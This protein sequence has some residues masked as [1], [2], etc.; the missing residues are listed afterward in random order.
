LIVSCGE[1]KTS[2]NYPDQ[3]QN[4]TSI[5]SQTDPNIVQ[6]G[7]ST[8]YILLAFALIVLIIGLMILFIPF[9]L[10]LKAVSSQIWIWPTT[11]IRMRLQH[12]D[13]HMIINTLISAKKAGLVVSLKEI[14]G[15]ALSN[16]DVE[17]VIH[18]AIT[19]HHGHIEVSVYDL[20][21]H[22][23]S[24]GSCHKVVHAMIAAHS[25][26]IKLPPDRQ[27]HLTFKTAAAIDHAK[28]DVEKA[29]DTYIKPKI[30]ETEEISGTPKDGVEVLA[31][32][33][34]TVRTN[35]NKII[36]GAGEET[37]KAQVCEK[38]ISIIGQTD[39]SRQIIENPFELGEKLMRQRIE[40]F[41]DTAYDVLS[42]DVGGVK[43]GKDTKAALATE[44][45][46]AKLISEKTREQE[47]KNL[48]AEAQIQHLHAESEVQRAM[49]DAF[50]DGHIDVHQY[51]KLLNTEADTIM[52]KSFSRGPHTDS[53]EVH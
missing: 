48:L 21:A 32:L 34:I 9:D 39:T 22:F 5:S 20:K 27:I 30:I 45:A 43:T 50:R 6:S 11:M 28:I 53:K 16:V 26:D 14:V 42:I 46:Q 1:D 25:A 8:L 4:E 2:G 10:W 19:A 13:L 23:L 51:H 15:L 41:K 35:I 12:L 37:I 3:S 17:E 44:R 52:R 40:L 24:G 36:F 7:S 47:I 18:S 49:A 29:I 33:R 31:K 38:A